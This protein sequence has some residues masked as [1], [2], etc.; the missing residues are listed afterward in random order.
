MSNQEYHI[1]I[2]KEEYEKL[3]YK[4]I[5]LESKIFNIEKKIYNIENKKNR[6]HLT[7]A[8]IKDHIENLILSIMDLIIDIPPD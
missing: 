1:V 6:F 2:K 4:I 5:A 8:Q 7:F 3:N